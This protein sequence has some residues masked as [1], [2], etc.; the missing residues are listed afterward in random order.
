M[1][2][3]KSC[4]LLEH[5]ICF[6][7]GNVCSC[8]YAPY[9]ADELVPLIYPSPAYNGENINKDFLYKI[10]NRHR[11]AAK[12]NQYI[13]SCEECYHLK[14]SDW[15]EE[16]YINQV[17]ITHFEECNSNCIYCINNLDNG[18]RKK[19]TYKIV[20]IIDD[21]ISQGILKEGCEFHIG[22]G[23]FSIYPECNEIIKK[24]VLSG[25]TK[26]LAIATNGIVFSKAIFEA[27][28]EG[29]ACIIISVDCGSGHLYKKIKRVDAFNKLKESLKLYTS[30]QKARE[31]TFLKYIVL[32]KINDS[33][34]EFRKFLSLAKK[35]GITGIKIDVDGKYC[36]EKSF[37]IE[38]NTLKFLEWCVQYASKKR[39]DVETFQFYN[40]CLQKSF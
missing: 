31:N 7:P 33:K 34:W 38:K 21:M 5:G 26:F 30:S 12:N 15:P 36:R 39:F 22:G 17:Y 40:Q 27:M 4:D 9:E 19:T 24:Y 6:Y 28:N 32:P 1:S 13:K 23:E 18:I 20:P 11:E 29:K 37:V 10:I 14:V 8:C 25:F 35:Y 16:N 3:Y 2:K